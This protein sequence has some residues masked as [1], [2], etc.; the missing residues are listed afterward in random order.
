MSIE[1]HTLP[2]WLNRF[3]WVMLK[4]ELL[5]GRRSGSILGVLCIA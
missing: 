5:G 2:D 4:T 3:V 1:L